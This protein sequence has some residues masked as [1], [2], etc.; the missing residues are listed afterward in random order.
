MAFTSKVKG[1]FSRLRNVNKSAAETRVVF[2][3]RPIE[4]GTM[5][6]YDDVKIPIQQF[7]FLDMRTMYLQSD[8][9]RTII[10][11]LVQETFRNKL[12]IVPKFNYKCAECEATYDYKPP[13]CEKC[14]HDI[15]ITPMK[16]ERELLE[17][18]VEEAN[19][20]KEHLLDVLKAMDVDINLYDNAFIVVLK[21][22]EFNEEGR[23]ET[24]RVREIFRADP[25]KIFMVINRNGRFGMT[26]DNR[27]VYFCLEHRTVGHKLT[28]TDIKMG[29]TKCPICGKEMYP[30]WFKAVPFAGSGFQQS[31]QVYYAPGEVLHIK[32]FG[33]GIGYGL[34]PLLTLW[35]KLMIL[36]RMDYYMLMAYHFGRPPKGLLIVRGEKESVEKAWDYMIEQ[37]R[38]NPHMIHPLVVEGE[39]AGSVRK[40]AEYID[41]SLKAEDT[42]FIEYR[43]E[44]RRAIGAV[45]GVLP[46]FQ[47]DVGGAGGLANEGLQVIVT[48]R[49]VRAE[50]EIFNEKVLKWLCKQ[51]GVND[52]IIRVK[53]NEARDLMAEIQRFE[54]RA[55][56]ATIMQQLGFEVHLI[57]GEDGLD[58]RY[59]E[60]SP[61]EKL[62]KALEAVLGR[63]VSNEE[64]MQILQQITGEGKIPE[65]QGGARPIGVVGGGGQ[66]IP[67]EGETEAERPRLEEQRVEGEPTGVKRRWRE[68]VREG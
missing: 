1:L 10:R 64:M 53:K 30:A 22:Y 33:H 9:L 39:E 11:V 44:L 61:E 37:T 24:A 14:G 41:L 52:W 57:E 54:A 48:N 67:V 32:K 23:I 62:R 26:D 43:N 16:D 29:N 12:E 68:I 38:L 21:E 7:T 3:Y 63:R 59:E 49:T 46:L 8:V 20:N 65:G 36:F 31:Q 34:S 5:I 58:F 25:S 18:F 27:F 47:S 40:V 17:K 6:S 35:I 45:Y 13:L 50:Q 2:L 60:K 55:R 51:I 4:M 42:A 28:D 19:T 56:V 66:V 15:F